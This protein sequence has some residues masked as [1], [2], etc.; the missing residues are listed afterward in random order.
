M[1]ADPGEPV[2]P[3]RGE[4]VIFEILHE[5]RELRGEGSCEVSGVDAEL[6]QIEFE[7]ILAEGFLK[8]FVRVSGEGL[9]DV[10]FGFEVLYD[11]FDAE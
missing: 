4:A 3:S 6:E 7:G 10:E 9:H 11:A 2:L 8:E 5:L 1:P